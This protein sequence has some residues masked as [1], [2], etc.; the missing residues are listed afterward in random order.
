V[1]RPEQRKG[2]DQE[3]EDAEPERTTRAG[4]T[5]FLAASCR[6]TTG[7]RRQREE[8]LP[9]SDREVVRGRRDGR[10]SAVPAVP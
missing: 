3:R 4:V 6:G 5:S 8:G 2:E 1:D 10:A 7:C 9:I